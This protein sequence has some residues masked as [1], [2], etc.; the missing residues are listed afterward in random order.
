MTRKRLNN[1]RMP[2][3]TALAL[4]A[5]LLSQ[6]SA[7][8]ALAGDTLPYEGISAKGENQP[9]QHGYTSAQIMDWTPESDIYGELL[10][11][12]VPLQPR[13]AAFAPT[14]A[15]PELSPDTQMF[16]MSGDY[17]NAFFDSTP[18]TNKFGQYLYNYWQYT[19][20]YGYW[21][22]MASAGVPE[23]LYDPK[24]D[25]TERYFEF[26]ILNIPNPAYTNAA[27]KNG[28]L[29]IANIFF[30]DNDRG[31][32]TYKQ[33][34]VQD[35]NGEFP[36][37]RKLVE[38][39]E[40]YGYDG[41]FF[42]QEE[43]AKG[44]AP[45][46]I[47]T[48]KRFMKYMRD[49]GMYVQWYDSTVDGTGKIAYQN[50]FNSANSPFVKDA[51]LGQVSDSIFLNYWWN[52]D[53]LTKSRSHAESLGLDP[54]ETVFAGVE[55]G[56]DSFGRWKQKYDLRWNL[57]ENGQPMNSIATLGADFT[58]NGLDEDMGNSSANHRADSEY[59]WMTF[60]RDR[61]WW[62]G[63]N[64]D[65]T[66][67][68]RNA[69]AN[70]A[71]VY[72][73]G[74]NW[75][76]I[77]AYIAERSVIR[78][79]NFFTSFNTGHGL[80]YVRNGTVSSDQEWSNINI[81]DIPV[82]WQWW[83]DTAGERLD[84]DFDY[85]PKYEKGARYDYQSIGAY[86]GGSSLV[87]NGNLNAENFLRL[88]KTDLTVNE[89]SK[90]TL[91]YNKPT[92]ADAS[93]L[94]LGLIFAETPNEV[95]K[96][97]VPDSGQ[98]TDG[99]KTV[100]LDL[101]PYAGK[102]IAAL[103]LSFD[104]NDST[105]NTYQ[106]NI[107]ELRITDGSAAKPEAPEGFRIDKAL[108]NTD[109][110]VVTWDIEDYDKVKQYNLYEN[111]AFVGGIYD[112]TYY[113]KSLKHMRGELAI[114]AVAAD[115]TESEPTTLPYDLTAGVQDVEVAFD[116]YGDASVT[117]KNPDDTAGP[118]E[119]TLET[120]YTNEPFTTTVQADAGEQ[121]A[122]I[123]GLPKNGQHYVLNISIDGQAPVT[124]TGQLADLEIT[125][126]AKELVTVTGKTYTLAL[127]TLTDWHRLYVYEN[128]VPREFGVTY[129]SKK[130]PYIVR[131]RTKLSELTFTPASTTSSLKLVIEDYAG[132]RA[133]TI[134]R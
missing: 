60:V 65:P 76:G 69:N 64:Q 117:W 95:V 103:G 126:Y 26:G 18:Y 80:D 87:V 4:S 14:Q 97:E 77:A 38:M 41:Y 98:Q 59:Q 109:E 127:P 133:T 114:T 88:F 70:L 9:Y 46:D 71:D 56:N 58:H 131:G 55:G 74:A 34:L 119:L 8:P 99:W 132:N 101:S 91:T 37:A 112:S 123:T 39:A 79:G 33:M 116:V 134:L 28:V 83:I 40:Y 113:I 62:S 96:V 6:L 93:S 11:A 124:V 29:S 42:N 75:D 36:V 128:D 20:Y 54:L 120:E 47:P 35:E 3:M 104:N 92:A 50:E 24:K 48:Y 122:V 7:T 45:A 72:A 121:Q 66:D 1:K 118:I 5:V 19:D 85:G 31:P 108:T 22:G 81:Q 84:V 43:V 94:S 21:H 78:G 90:A 73:S 49:Q 115:G 125:P 23:E 17:G 106:M 32:Q 105:I 110:M 51:Q 2:K 57:D 12:R 16:T 82:T 30:S 68:R 89:H 13:N 27:H 15:S 61:A 52:H 63:P 53:M 111:G 10:R 107:G 44:V 25:W 86:N 102:N 130:F 100:S 67:A 129:V